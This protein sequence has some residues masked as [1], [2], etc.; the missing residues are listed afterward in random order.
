M[1]LSG[2]EIVAA[3][4]RGELDIEP[5]CLEQVNPNS[6]NFRLAS[7]FVEL[8]PHRQSHRRSFGPHGHLLVPGHL[9]LGCT[10]EIIG[11]VKYAM[12]LLGRSSTGRLGLFLNITADLGHV[13]S[14][15][16]WTLEMTVVQP[17]RVYSGMKIGQV[18]FWVQS[19]ST[20]GYSGRYHGDHGPQP[21]RDTSLDRVSI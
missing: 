14:T 17:L 15:S 12:T 2:Y 3:R 7:T 13:G 5:F 10:N 19:G 20:S 21:N 8:Y 11:S 1:I 6:Y 4:E 16:R 18:A 9:Y